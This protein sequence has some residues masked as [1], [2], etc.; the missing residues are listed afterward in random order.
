MAAREGVRSSARLSGATTA[1]SAAP[2]PAARD[3][4]AEEERAALRKAR[5]ARAV[6][7]AREVEDSPQV[8]REKCRR[9]ARALREAK[10]LVVPFFCHTFYFK[11]PL[12]FVTYIRVI[13]IK[14]HNYQK[15]NQKNTNYICICEIYFL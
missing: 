3:S 6:E 13:N 1:A 11:R 2:A 7:R 15:V 14:P 5:A 4:L 8:L 10:H 9:L 12:H